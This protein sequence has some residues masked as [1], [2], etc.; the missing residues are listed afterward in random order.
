M[1]MVQDTKAI[2]EMI[3]NTAMEKRSGQTVLA[4]SVIML[5][6][7]SKEEVVMNGLT[8][9]LMMGNGITIK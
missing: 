1:Q 6:V 7:R 4:I 3:Y 9:Q 2:G 5:M 8:D